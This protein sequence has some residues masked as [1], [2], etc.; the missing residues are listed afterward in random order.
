[1][2]GIR[3]MPRFSRSES[4]IK[5]NASAANS[6]SWIETS[7][8]AKVLQRIRGHCCAL[9][10]DVQKLAVVEQ[11]VEER[12]NRNGNLSGTGHPAA[13]NRTQDG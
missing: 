10:S 12:L 11:G 1:M 2:T 4:R 6:E 9:L 7:M 5:T 3:H 8:A 13:C